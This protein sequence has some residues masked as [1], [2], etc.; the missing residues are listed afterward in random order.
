MEKE[1]RMNML[2]DKGKIRFAVTDLM[3]IVMSILLLCGINFWFPVCTATGEKVMS[4]HWA[5]RTLSAAAWLVLAIA[6]IHLAVPCDRIKTGMDI[7]CA[8]ISVFI[9]MIP[10]KVIAICRDSSMH[11]HRT[12]L[13]TGVL[14]LIMIIFCI[15]D[16]IFRCSY[17]TRKKHERPV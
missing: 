1:E 12:A 4:C 8:L 15:A 11:C 9:M 17:E 13:W 10:G 14:C 6:L 7:S 3:L 5:G 16:I 2:V